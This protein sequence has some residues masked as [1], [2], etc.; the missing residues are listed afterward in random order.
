MLAWDTS[1]A[2]NHFRPITYI[3]TVLPHTFIHAFANLLVVK[4]FQS[5]PVVGKRR[6]SFD[7]TFKIYFK[8]VKEDLDIIGRQIFK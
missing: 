3:N 7:R 2:N 5:P 4:P 8:P 1:D 6:M